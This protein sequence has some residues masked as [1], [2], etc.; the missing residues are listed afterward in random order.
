MVCMLDS[1]SKAMKRF[2]HCS[3][4]WCIVFLSK[5]LNSH[6]VQKPWDKL[7]QV[8]DTWLPLPHLIGRYFDFLILPFGGATQGQPWN[9][10]ESPAEKFL[11]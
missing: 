7:W 5:A 4:L 2:K 9:L 1:K 11:D 10:L 6:G 3:G 8:W